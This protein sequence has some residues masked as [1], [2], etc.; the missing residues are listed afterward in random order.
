MLRI[1]IVGTGRISAKHIG[2][3]QKLDNA[4]ITA[5]CDIDEEK[6]KNVGD[7]LN[8]PE[9]YRFVNYM[10]LI[11]CPE[12]DAVEICTPNY[13]HVPMALEVVKAGK[14]VEIEKPLTTFYKSDA[15]ELLKSIEDKKIANMMCF[16]YRFMP[17]VRY[18]KHLL[19]NNMLGK[20][21]NVNVEYLQSGVFI[22]GR[23]LEWRFVKEF[24]GTGTLC[25]LGSHLIDMTRFLV[26]DF[27][28]VCGMS[29]IVVK[30]RKKLD[31]E[32]YA[33][34]DTD[35][36]TSFI[37]RLEND[38]LANFLVTKCA[39]GE[40]N[41]IKY[42]IYGTDGVIKFNLNNPDE[43]TLCVGEVD[44]ET[45]GTHTVMVPAEYRLSQEDAFVRSALGEE[46][47]YYPRAE[48]GAK[49]QKILDAVAKS[50][51]ENKIVYLK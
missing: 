17:A 27:V 14:H 25:D 21:V 37:A 6:L 45:G 4:V 38:V 28:S 33:N 15:E 19:E 50:A 41:T 42:E 3:L 5:I 2:E 22:K 23:R 10:D 18:A 39:I 34:V 31:S 20:I 30:E 49:C 35:D 51:A 46:T 11:K 40:G 13:L 8:I 24:S 32:E 7:S 48:E 16:S 12:V 29:N 44:K 36:L 47:P 43:I 26:G 1:G 9:E